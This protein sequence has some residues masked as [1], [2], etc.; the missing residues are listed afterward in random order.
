M[1]IARTAS[2]DAVASRIQLGQFIVLQRV[3]RSMSAL[4]FVRA[5]ARR[6]GRPCVVIQDPLNEAPSGVRVLD[7]RSVTAS[8]FAAWQE[9]RSNLGSPASPLV[10]LLDISS[11]LRILESAP[12]L[13]S[14]AGGVQSPVEPIAT[15]RTHAQAQQG[16]RSLR[17][18]LVGDPKFAS[19]NMGRLIAVE[20]S[21]ER[22]FE[23]RPGESA[24][25][26]ASGALDD[27]LLHL[28]T[29][30]PEDLR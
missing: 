15:T 4:D 16:Q 20:I 29:L 18:A 3:R 17:N 21:S 19:R 27:G 24:Y 10:V 22:L 23:A 6:V 25:D 5:L 13:V 28:L 1:S 12:H 11:E 30:R 7:G 8:T 14:W 9:C 2:A 26:V